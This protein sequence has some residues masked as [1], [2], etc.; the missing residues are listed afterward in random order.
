M[1]YGC[2]ENTEL[3]CFADERG[4]TFLDHLRNRP[5]GL[6]LA[7]QSL[8]DMSGDELIQQSLRIQPSLRSILLV[9]DQSLA[10]DPSRPY[11][12]DVVVASRDLLKEDQ[13][14]RSAMLAAI[15]GASYRSPSIR[16]AGVDHPGTGL[17]LSEVEKAIL[18]G[19]AS[20]L[21]LAEISDRLPQTASTIKTYSRNLLQKMGVNNRQKALAKALALGLFSQRRM[22]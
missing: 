2:F 19:Y 22:L 8:I 11:R 20:G 13:A 12:S 6:L 21:T 14:L 15:G 3:I 17:R 4:S 5:C 16:P 7:T 10:D 1:V 18:E 9:E